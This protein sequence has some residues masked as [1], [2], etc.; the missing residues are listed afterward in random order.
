[1]SILASINALVKLRNRLVFLSAGFVLFL[2]AG[3]GVFAVTIQDERNA[4]KEVK[5][6]AWAAAKSGAVIARAEKKLDKVLAAEKEAKARVAAAKAALAAADADEEAKGVG[7]LFRGRDPKAR[8]QKRQAALERIEKETQSLRQALADAQTEHE[9]NNVRLRQAE[10]IAEDMAHTRQVAARPRRFAAAAEGRARRAYHEALA[11]HE[12]AR[13][14]AAAAAADAQQSRRQIDELKAVQK[15]IEQEV[16]DKTRLA[17]SVG[18]PAEREQRLRAMRE[19]EARATVIGKELNDLNSRVTKQT[20]AADK[21]RKK[22]AMAQTILNQA[23]KGFQPFATAKDARALGKE[24]DKA[25]KE[26]QRRQRAAAADD[27]RDRLKGEKAKRKQQQKLRRERERVEREAARRAEA[28]RKAKE[29]AKREAA[30]QAACQAQAQCK[31]A[32][33]VARKLSKE[34]RDAVTNVEL[35]RQEAVETAAAYEQAERRYMELKTVEAATRKAVTGASRAA[36]EATNRIERERFV[37]AMRAAEVKVAEISR[38]M[39]NRKYKLPRLAADT[40]KAQQKVAMAATVLAKAEKADAAA[41]AAAASARLA[42]AEQ[43]AAVRRLAA[44]QRAGD[45]KAT[46]AT[47]RKAEREAAAR[48]ATERWAREKAERQAAAEQRAATRKAEAERKAKKKAERESARQAEQARKEAERQAARERKAQERAERESARLAEKEG[49]AREIAAR[50]TANLAAEEVLRQRIKASEDEEAKE[51][52]RRKQ[53]KEAAKAGR[54]LER[55]E[56]RAAREYPAA[57]KRYD[58]AVT[59]AKVSAERGAEAQRKIN[60]LRSQVAAAEVEVTGKNERVA[61]ATTAAPAESR[62][63]NK[64][65]RAAEKS[66]T[67]LNRKLKKADTELAAT[68]NDFAA[69]EAVRAAASDHLKGIREQYAEFVTAMDAEEAERVAAETALQEARKQQMQAKLETE[70]RAAA[71]RLAQKKEERERFD[72]ERRTREKL[73]AAK[74][75]ER[76]ADRERRRAEKLAE[77]ER[78]EAEEG[79]GARAERQRKKRE[80]AEAQRL[81]RL[82]Q[83]QLLTEKREAKRIEKATARERKE[84]ERLVR[85]AAREEEHQAAKEKREQDRNAVAEEKERLRQLKVTQKIEES[86]YSGAYPEQPAP[87]RTAR[88]DIPQ[89]TKYDICAVV[90]TGDRQPVEQLDNWSDYENDALYTPMTEADVENFRQSILK[91]LQD[92]GYVFAT[93][94]VYRP[95]LNL[96]FLKIRVHVGDKGNV[97]VVGNRWHT[98]RQILEAA[99]WETGSKFNYRDLYS[100]LFGLNVRPDLN[101]NTRLKPRVD[102]HGR[103]IVDVEL[104]VKDS[105]PLHLSLNL[106]NTGTKE[107]DDWRLRTVLQHLNLTKRGDILTAEWLTD[108]QNMDYINAFS[109]SYYLPMSEQRAL[110]VYAGYSESDI[111]DVAPELDIYGEGRYAGVNYTKVFKDTR[112]YTL[113]GGIGWLYQ[114]VENI[115]DV[116]GVSFDTRE[117][118]LSMPSVTLGYSAKIFDKYGGRNYISGTLMANRSGHF[119][120]SPDNEF[121]EQNPHADGNFMI[122]RIQAARFQKLFSGDEEPGKWSMFMKADVQIADDSLVS[123]VRK[124]IG[125]ASSVRG[126]RERMLDG[127]S[128]YNATLEL[129]TPLLDNFLPGMRQTEEFL[130]EHPDHWTLHRLQAV[131]F[132]DYGYV[133][134]NTPQEGEL[135]RDNLLGIG[136]GLRIGLT[137]NLQM[138]FDYGVALDRSNDADSG[139]GH[140]Q[141]QVQF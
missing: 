125:G 75:A 60:Y 47:V 80:Q 41:D 74:D 45:E 8:L 58:K 72:A 118:E 57:K 131:L 96:G 126:Y 55:A 50:Q 43:L 13:R 106:S 133:E 10:R 130:R 23:E 98:A 52:I 35:A 7:R 116:S 19:A 28:E 21:E 141:L 136:G 14:N 63:L 90:V 11:R 48:A 77:K 93:V 105:F 79:E 138:R 22:A 70:V 102:E 85:K 87:P 33:R 65:L 139:R 78:R 34:S 107:T 132:T 37:K 31:A 26:A 97:T 9:A 67:R 140:L 71:D 99:Q 64:E 95:S 111:N 5:N 25:M 42:E 122:A 29:K 54:A 51:R 89:G 101:V 108:P 120:S 112:E 32:A 76:E 123:A 15:A 68:Q 121:A 113:D 127:D 66:S 56:R 20:Q 86:K 94:S 73:K 44:D 103:R 49:K 109:L 39:K 3:F 110:S 82:E 69:A 84:A 128:G 18:N 134:N 129:R 135:R 88:A 119:L 30:R 24:R 100:D 2:S 53:E 61:A 59:A 81:A 6:A 40:E 36:G 12:Q 92:D 114:Y 115:S 16:A 124:G 27:V 1:M 46:L 17:S 104:N 83:K 62:A 91:E 38:E 4:A 117:I 137:K